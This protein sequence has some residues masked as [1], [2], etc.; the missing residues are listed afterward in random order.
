MSWL[1]RTAAPQE[2]LADFFPGNAFN[3]TRLELGSS[4]LDFC[5]PGRFD[6]LTWFVSETFYQE[7]SELRAFLLF[8][9]EC[10]PKHILGCRLH[11]FILAHDDSTHES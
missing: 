2:S 10:L 5:Y 3:G 1:C 8:E 9:L 11:S 4:S 7:N 6:F